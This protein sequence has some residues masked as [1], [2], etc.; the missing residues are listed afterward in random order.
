MPSVPMAISFGAKVML[1]VL[2]SNFLPQLH[3]VNIAHVAVSES[4][5]L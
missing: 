1:V 4:N 5:K 2:K 3:P